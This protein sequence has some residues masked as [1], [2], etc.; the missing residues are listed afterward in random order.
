MRKNPYA[1]LC[2]SVQALR[3]DFEGMRT[4]LA[5]AT[6]VA[7]T[8]YT[9]QIANVFRVLTDV[10]VRHLLADEVGLGKTV[11][12]LMILNALRYQRPD[13]R[14]LVVVPQ[15]LVTQWRDEIM[16]RAHSVPVETEEGFEDEQYIR[17]AWETQ[18][19]TRTADGRTAWSLSDIDPSRYQTLVVDELHSLRADVQDRIVRVAGAFE[20]VLALTATPAFQ[21]M[22]RHAQL[23]ALLEPERSAIIGTKAIG[24]GVDTIEAD[25]EDYSN[26]TEQAAK[27]VVDGMLARDENAK[28]ACS[29]A[30]MTSVAL[31]HCA[32]RRVIR[33]RR[34]DYA[35][36]LPRRRHMTHLVEPLEAE[37]ER[38]TLMWSYIGRLGT[39]GRR[40]DPVPLAKRVVLS[41]PSLR[42]RVGE[43]IR[44]DLDREGL[45]EA[46]RPLADRSRG[47]SR[48]DELVDLLAEV[49]TR[50][51]E[52]RVLVAVQDNP[53]V[54]YL[55]ELV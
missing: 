49:W 15:G 36:V 4:P 54:D 18:L 46:V 16:A 12:A 22:K 10:R 11:Q 19:G 25:M 50:N 6:G 28:S 32:Y 41:P 1:N 33:T 5:P 2:L 40:V 45:L 24:P 47:D 17:L 37:V 35:G 38:Q 3:R 52:E 31:A 8:V 42:E 20:H 34:A 39:V 29:P 53:T 44:A 48:A 43:L 26:W 55:F 21:N 14:A 13:L 30:D 27:A 7:S 9:H 51:P 23:F